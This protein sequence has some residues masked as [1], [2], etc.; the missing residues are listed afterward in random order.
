MITL[1]NIQC[2][3]NYFFNIFLLIEDCSI[4]GI[5]T[6]QDFDL[7]YHGERCSSDQPQSLTC[8]YCGEM[9]LSLPYLNESSSSNNNN[10]QSIDLFQHLQLKHT[11]DQQLPEVICPVCA[12]MTNAEPNLVT[13]DLIS[14]IANDHQQSQGS[15]PST[16]SD[17]TN[18]FA[19]QAS[20]TRDYDFGIA[21]GI[22]GGFRR[23]SLRTPGRRGGLGRGSGP[24]SQH[25]VVDPSSGL[26]AGGGGSDPIAD[27]LTQ[28][29][30]VR[31][32]ASANN[33]SS[34][35]PTANTINLQTFT[36]QQYERERLRGTG[37]SHH[38]HHHHYS[39][40]PTQ[41]A[42]ASDVL[43]SAENDLFDSLFS[44]TLVIDPS[45][46]STNNQRTWT[47]ILAQPQ[48]Q[49]QS[50]PDQ[51]SQTASTTTK[52]TNTDA[53]PSLLRRICDEASSSLL[54]KNA[55]IVQSSKPKSDF[56]QSLLLSSF[57]STVNDK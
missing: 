18:I 50:T 53:D 55:T 17:G 7:Y 2:N 32:L 47:H 44:S 12:S 56:V 40:H 29:S 10:T 30:S 51:Q 25:F 6:R 4:V 8:P 35:P 57:F 9:G 11:S 33:N 1:P 28:L 5:L 19:R 23:G 48:S 14:H 26:S 16:A 20:S 22:R 54:Q 36:R 37:R 21:A 34:L 3:V 27:L 46:A 52:P 24:V 43:S 45:S 13:A 31:R 15:T 41:S 39:Q 42:G 38:H 49:Q